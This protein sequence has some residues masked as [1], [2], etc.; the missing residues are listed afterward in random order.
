MG[1]NGSPAPVAERWNPAS[2]WTLQATATPAKATY[3]ELDGVSCASATTCT[4]AGHYDILKPS[5]L[6][7]PLAEHE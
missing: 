7:H 5:T 1:N 2:G 6:G 4:A 3:S